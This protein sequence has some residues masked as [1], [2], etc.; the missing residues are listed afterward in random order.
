[1]KTISELHNTQL[2]SIKELL[3]KELVKGVTVHGEFITYEN[4][5]EQFACIK[6]DGISG[7]SQTVYS[8]LIPVEKLNDTNFCIEHI[9]KDIEKMDFIKGTVFTE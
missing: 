8:E 5:S 9:K 7:F 6:F 1:M 2:N 4:K 3:R